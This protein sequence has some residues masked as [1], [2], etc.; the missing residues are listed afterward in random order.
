MAA[1]GFNEALSLDVVSPVYGNA[2]GGEPAPIPRGIGHTVHVNGQPFI[3][4]NSL[5]LKAM[6]QVRGAR[7]E[8]RS[9]APLNARLS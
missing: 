5:T 4:S 7:E 2:E 8:K 1:R 9:H 3:G 6:R